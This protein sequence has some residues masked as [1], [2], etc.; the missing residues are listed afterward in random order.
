MLA[1]RAIWILMFS[2][3][4]DGCNSVSGGDDV[5][6]TE[7]EITGSSPDLEEGRVPIDSSID[8]GKFNIAWKVDDDNAIRY[9][10]GFYLSVNDNL[11]TSKDI[12]FALFSCD[13]FSDCDHD[14][15]NDAD[16]YF[17][18]NL[19]MYCGKDDSRRYSVDELIDALPA[20]LY[21]IIH[22]CNGIDCDTEAKP[23]RLR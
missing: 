1:R 5:K 2:L 7:F 16:C 15:R 14:K 13:D 11:S 4:L 9:T 21:I 19:E 12:R 20:D 3:F 10:A 22:A 17:T 18:N 8:G 6:V 23:I